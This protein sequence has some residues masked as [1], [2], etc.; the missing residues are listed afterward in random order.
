[1]IRLPVEPAITEFLH[2]KATARRIPLSGTFELTPVC[3]MN[4]RMCY[5]RMSAQQQQSIRP[6]KTAEQWLEIAAQ[7]KKEGLLYL[8]LTGG[9][10]F[11]YPGFRKLLA[12]LQE[13]GFIIS[14]NSNGTM[15]DEETVS[16]LKK[17]P[18]MRI[19]ITLY[20]ASDATYEKLCANPKGFTQTT[21]AIRLLR[22][23]GITVKLNC[24]ITPYNAADFPEIIAYA[25]RENLV[26]QASSYMFPPLRKD[27]RMVG[28][29][30]R[31]TP[32]EAAYYSAM[33]EYL[34][35]GKEAFLNRPEEE[36]PALPSDANED[37]EAVGD[38]IRCRAGKCSFWITWEGNMMACGMFPVVEENNVFD[39]DFQSCWNHVVE[40][41]NEIRLPAQCTSCT[42][43]EHC[44]ACAAMVI[45][46]SGSFDK[47]PQYR[48]Q[49]SKAYPNERRKLKEQLLDGA[50]FLR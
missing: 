31:F 7:A 50:D 49:M 13:M 46:E 5:V 15:I 34:L 2:R 18:P 30:D 38:F 22:E 21:N 47:V 35:N 6:L 20:G 27:P 29:N 19:N 10:P 37:C 39:L 3:N 45:T 32:E 12:G 36:L 40:T 41:T 33:T 23:A 43:R 42:C 16:W 26:V 1:M 9:E 24:S 28:S 48:C 17:T 25:Q 14:I 8:L 44:K 11:L 4:C